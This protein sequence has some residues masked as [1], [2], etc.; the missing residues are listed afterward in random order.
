MDKLLEA[1]TKLVPAGV[2]IGIVA[3]LYL[4]VLFKRASDRFIDLSQ[5]QSEFLKDRIEIVDKTS[6]IFSRT[7][8]QQEKEIRKLREDLESVNVSLEQTRLSV[9][10]RSVEEFKVLAGTVRKVLS[11][12]E[13]TLD[14]MAVGSGDD[15]AHHN[16]LVERSGAVSRSFDGEIPNLLKKRD[17]S[18]YI[19]L[20]T[21]LDGVGELVAGLKALGL[22]AS[23]Y[24]SPA[25]IEGD[26]LNRDNHTAIW[27]GR[28]V[29]AEIVLSSIRVARQ[30]WPFLVYIYISGDLSDTPPEEV[31]S[32]LYFGGSTRTARRYGL[33]PWSNAEVEAL[34]SSASNEDFH[35]AIRS[36]YTAAEM[37][38]V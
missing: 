1:L 34:D 24:D 21:R 3:F 16:L 12:Q 29:P 25:W 5:K 8:D 38:K 33:L 32:Q 18:R 14:L 11:L 17:L 10:D 19:V 7:I 26:D 27:V 36:H 37:A 9:T 28:K 35:S 23:V 6:V 20:A 4:V 30:H 2:A 15:L 22:A 13:A 31:H